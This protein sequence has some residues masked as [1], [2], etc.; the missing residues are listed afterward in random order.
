[1]HTN[2]TYCMEKTDRQCIKPQAGRQG[3]SS[4]QVMAVQIQGSHSGRYSSRRN[5]C[6][7]KQKLWNPLT[8]PLSFIRRSW[9]RPPL[10]CL[11]Q[12]PRWWHSLS[13]VLSDQEQ[14][15]IQKPLWTGAP[16]YNQS[17]STSRRIYPT[18][19]S[20][21]LISTYPC[22]PYRQ[23]WHASLSPWTR[24]PR[25]SQWALGRLYSA[26]Q[27]SKPCFKQVPRHQS[28]VIIETSVMV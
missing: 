7:R 20:G 9:M 12:A 22:Y 1:M 5:T 27:P 26:S 11:V 13:E 28:L 14:E 24:H 17:Q 4:E 25:F 18:G 23:C 16:D 3:R 8:T 15:R 21:Y 2:A 6:S 10:I 19:Y